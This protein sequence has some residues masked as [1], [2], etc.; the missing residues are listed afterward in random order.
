MNFFRYL[1]DGLATV[2]NHDSWY[3]RRRNL[4]PLFHRSQLRLAFDA[5]NQA[6]DHL[7][8]ELKEK[9][10]SGKPFTF[11]PLIHRSTL[12]VIMRVIFN[13]IPTHPM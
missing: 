8:E 7:T 11:A 10:E 12:D 2:I 13:T 9:A 6:A 3:I 1:G 4:D 5:Y